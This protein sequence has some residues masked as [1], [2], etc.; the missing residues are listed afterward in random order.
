M[1]KSMGLAICLAGSAGIGS[2]LLGRGP[3]AAPAGRGD[4]ALAAATTRAP[5]AAR[6]PELIEASF[7]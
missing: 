4:E 5:A 2:A 3:N 6:Q 1:T 7:T